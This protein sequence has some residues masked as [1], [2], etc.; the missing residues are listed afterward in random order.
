MKKIFFVSLVVI[1]LGITFVSATNYDQA[2]TNKLKGKLLLAVEDKGRIWYVNQTDGKRYEVTFENALSLFQR[3]SLGINNADLE[4]MPLPNSKTPIHNLAKRLS[5]KFLLQVQDK[6]RIWYVS[7][8][9]YKRHEVTWVNLMDLFR[10]LSLGV[11]NENLNKIEMGE[12]I[13]KN[14]DKFSFVCPGGWTLSENKDYGGNVLVGQCGKVYSRQYALDDGININFGFVPQN[15]A[16]TYSY[17]E[18]QGKYSEMIFNEI[19]NES[20]AQLYENGSF[21]GWISMKNQKHTMRIIARY[22]VE[23]GYYEV[24]ANASGNTKTDQEFKKMIDDIIETFYI[25]L[26]PFTYTNNNELFD[27]VSK[28][29]FKVLEKF[30]ADELYSNRC[31]T[32]KTKE[33]FQ[34]VLSRYSNEDLGI[35]YIFEYNGITQEPG[36]WVVRVIQNKFDYENMDD[37]QKD[38]GVCSA[39]EEKYPLLFSGKYLLFMSSCGSGFDDGSG[40]PHGCDLIQEFVQPT[41]RIK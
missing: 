17:S 14:S 34:N 23:D 32:D 19:K 29:E 39:G 8:S 40:R 7:P 4:S 13:Y 11:T 27:K 6:G 25:K 18:V 28:Q 1:L 16:N 9:D 35:E 21:S 2:L 37:F 38:F 36:V 5:G 3:F 31:D 10:K 33:Y 24:R 22:Q 30:T 26:E 41:I 20:N 15:L 12:N